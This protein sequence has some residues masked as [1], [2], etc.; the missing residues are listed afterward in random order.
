MITRATGVVAALIAVWPVIGRADDAPALAS[1]PCQT[2]IE[3]VPFAAAAPRLA[4]GTLP[5]Y[6]SIFEAPVGMVID[7]WTGQI[8]W[9]QP[10]R[11]VYPITLCATGFEGQD[12]VEWILRVVPNDFGDPH[13]YSTTHVD[14]VA[15]EPFI[16]WMTGWKVGRYVDGAWE[17]MRD[18]LGQEPLD[19]KQVVRYTSSVSTARGGNPVETGAAL[20][21]ADPILGWG[22][23][24][25]LVGVSDNFLA[26]TRIGRITDNNWADRFFNGGTGMVRILV[27][28]RALADPDTFGLSG[29]R[30][31]G[32]QSWVE[33]READAASRSQDY[34]QWLNQGGTAETY[35]GDGTGAWEW[36][37]RTLERGYPGMLETTL[38]ALRIDG[39]AAIVYD[40]ADTPLRKNSLLFCIMS[41]A[42]ETDLRTFFAG[43]GW[44]FDDDFYDLIWPSVSQ[45]IQ[46]LP[47]DE[48]VRGWKRSP[49]NGH[50]YRLTGWSMTWSEAER[51]ARRLGGHL[52]TLRSA[53]EE[54]WLISRL[55]FETNLWSGFNDVISEGVWSWTSGEP[56]LY[57]RWGAG[58]PNGG[59]LENGMLFYTWWGDFKSWV[60]RPISERYLG[61][62]E[63]TSLPELVRADWDKDGDVDLNDL[64]LFDICLT[65]PAVPLMKGCASR[66][67]D[68]D[69]DVDQDDFG[70]AQRCL[71]GEG[72]AA[73]PACD[74]PAQ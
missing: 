39:L 34:I 2:A 60:D 48:D 38:R 53:A 65:G 70:L 5:V 30:L 44:T 26:R 72:V 8:T 11:G 1:Y 68:G 23:G 59:I 73:D 4:G 6:W 40:F 62:I 63:R 64:D 29:Q 18:V 52:V 57:T 36:I 21:S 43:W 45:G 47:Q 22:L 9:Q 54:Q 51:S 20:W 42:A 37:C 56:V 49:I 74:V 27:E 14:F 31:E 3:W 50:Y 66:D 28:T 7:P 12:Y 10:L 16:Q 13:M 17:Y 35:F 67:L 25:W 69:G 71:S 58:E 41:A 61:V 46:S 15:P 33:S 19:G 32:F 55:G 24:N